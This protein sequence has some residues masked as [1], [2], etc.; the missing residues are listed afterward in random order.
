MR[1]ASAVGVSEGILEGCDEGI[2]LCVQEGIKEG[3]DEGGDDTVG[4]RDTDGNDDGELDIVG[5]A[6]FVGANVGGIVVSVSC[7]MRNL[8]PTAYFGAMSRAV[9]RV[10]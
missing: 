9:S 3:T 7:S 8:D 5:V 6:D 4:A 2:M 10:L 1:E